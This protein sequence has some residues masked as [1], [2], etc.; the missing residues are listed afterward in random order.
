MLNNEIKKNKT[1]KKMIQKTTWV[2]SGQ[3][4]KYYS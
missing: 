1:I 2:N 3:P 4:V